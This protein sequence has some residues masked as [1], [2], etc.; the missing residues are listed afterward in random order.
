ML[1]RE[2]LQEAV[3]ALTWQ[4]EYVMSSDQMRK[5]NETA[6][7]RK[8]GA[9]AEARAELKRMDQKTTPTATK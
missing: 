1:S 6:L 9:L 2:T 5:S 7:K 4:I 3:W 8:M